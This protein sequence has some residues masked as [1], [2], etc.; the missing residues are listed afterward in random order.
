MTVYWLKYSDFAP[1]PQVLVK[2]NTILNQII[3]TTIQIN[4]EGSNV[5]T[6]I[7]ITFTFELL[8]G[9]KIEKNRQI[10]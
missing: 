6:H 9:P 4:K 1:D 2:I 7:H 5:T 10:L 3:H 8:M